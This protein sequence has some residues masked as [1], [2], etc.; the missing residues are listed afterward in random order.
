MPGSAE[1][2]KGPAFTNEKVGLVTVPTSLWLKSRPP[3]RG[4]RIAQLSWANN[5]FVANLW[6]RP[7][8]VV[9]HLRQAANPRA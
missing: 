5:F 7:P 8:R 1:L 3:G 2:G 9:P 6:I 4:S